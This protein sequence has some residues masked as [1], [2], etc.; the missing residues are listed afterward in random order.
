MEGAKHLE[1]PGTTL[2]V[3]MRSMY[4]V[5]TITGLVAASV[6]T[7]AAQPRRP[8]R[9]LPPEP[10]VRQEIRERMLE[11]REA[12]IE[13]RLGRGG[14]GLRLQGHR[15]RAIMGG[16]MGARM[17]GR[18]GLRAGERAR[19]ERRA[20]ARERYEA[21]QPAQREALFKYRESARTE[22]FRVGEDLR[23]GKIT[24]EQA[25]ERLT[26]WRETNKPPVDLR[27]PNPRRP[28]E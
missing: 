1:R 9:P 16:R 6:S 4:R 2:E 19:I 26:K 20:V 17:G 28:G 11:R 12:M 21:L 5:V 15:G 14:A 8:I 18:A 24:R 23:A 3:C 7:L 13:R 27:G 22:R 25:R 10:P